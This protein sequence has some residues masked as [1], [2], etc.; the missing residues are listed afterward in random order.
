MSM[1]GVNGLLFASFAK[2]QQA[3]RCLFWIWVG[4][5]GTGGQGGVE[6][7]S[8][9]FDAVRFRMLLRPGNVSAMLSLSRRGYS[10][11]CIR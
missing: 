10:V 5:H 6:V 11:L 7:G 3:H 2:A 9:R 8:S 1:A 4:Q